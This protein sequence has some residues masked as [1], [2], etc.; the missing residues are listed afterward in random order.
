MYEW[1]DEKSE[2]N[3]RR[4]GFGFEVVERFDFGSGITVPDDRQEY[5][6]PRFRSIGWIDGR[7]FVVVWTP[8]GTKLRIISVRH[9]HLKEWRQYE[10]DQED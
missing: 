2:H 5:G 10:Q 7:L 3:R 6:E 1:D 9:A 8:R 4:R